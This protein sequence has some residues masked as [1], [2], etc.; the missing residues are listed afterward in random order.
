M[1]SFSSEWKHPP[2]QQDESLS[3]Q[4]ANHVAADGHLWLLA[5]EAQESSLYSYWG[6]SYLQRN[7]LH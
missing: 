5:R 1:Q 2:H 3:V 7:I 6:S 4:K